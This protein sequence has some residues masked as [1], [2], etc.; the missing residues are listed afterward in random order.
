[1]FG[2]Y[3]CEANV[4]LSHWEFLRT[5]IVFQNI[6]NGIC[7]CNVRTWNSFVVV[8]DKLLG[9]CA[10][11][12]SLEEFNGSGSISKGNGQATFHVGTL[13]QTP[14]LKSFA[15]ASTVSCA[16]EETQMVSA[17]EGSSIGTKTYFFPNAKQFDAWNSA[18]IQASLFWRSE[19]DCKYTVSSVFMKQ[20]LHNFQT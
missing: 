17:N 10:E 5:Q 12:K 7:F 4:Y 1:M 19:D 9:S 14:T 16:F 20:Y 11:H 2:T 18:K 6:Y 3:F 15:L 8:V 13:F